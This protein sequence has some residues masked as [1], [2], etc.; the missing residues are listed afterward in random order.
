MLCFYRKYTFIQHYTWSI[1]WILS[2]RLVAVRRQP[3]VSRTVGN[4]VQKIRHW[5]IGSKL[6]DDS[7]S[8]VTPF[9]SAFIADDGVAVCHRSSKDVAWPIEGR[10]TRVSYRWAY[11]LSSA[12]DKQ[13]PLRRWCSH[14]LSEVFHCSFSIR[15]FERL[16]SKVDYAIFR[17]GK[18]MR[19]SSSIT[20]LNRRRRVNGLRLLVSLEAFCWLVTW[21]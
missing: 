13:A 7:F 12:R 11:S 20:S 1:L 19:L 21:P 9:S 8:L 10:G 5:S 16:A 4:L 6:I 3:H 2:P 18:G 14:V 17:N 15:Q